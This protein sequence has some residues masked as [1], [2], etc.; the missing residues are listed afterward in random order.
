M[1]IWIRKLARLIFRNMM[2]VPRATTI[3][4]VSLASIAQS[5]PPS[6]NSSSSSL[7][8]RGEAR[9]PDDFDRVGKTVDQLGDCLIDIALRQADGA[10]AP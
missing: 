3:C 6:A 4:S 9:K 1:R 7:G 5:S 8:F 2:P 10:L